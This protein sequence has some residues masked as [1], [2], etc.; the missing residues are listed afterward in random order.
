MLLNFD[1]RASV[2]ARCEFYA[3]DWE[4][5]A[6]LFDDDENRRCDYIFT[7]ETIYNQDNY[8]KLHEVFKKRLKINGVAWV[9]CIASS[10]FTF[11]RTATKS[12]YLDS[13]PGKHIILV[14][15]VGWGNSNV[16]CWKKDTSMSRR[17]GGIKMVIDSNRKCIF[18]LF[19]QFDNVCALC[20]RSK[21]WNTKTHEEDILID[22]VIVIVRS[23]LHLH[24]T[25]Q[26]LILHY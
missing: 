13:L 4:S 18:V 22:S 6:T 20:F 7:S 21:P 16:L 26:N 2:L 9:H 24:Y 19:Y 23:T 12:S 3:G 1:D 14:W 8:R 10:I 25:R 11:V 5:F 17:S 15:V